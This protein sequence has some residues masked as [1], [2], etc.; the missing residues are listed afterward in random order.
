MFTRNPRVLFIRTGL[1]L[2]C[3][4]T[5]C[6]FH[7]REKCRLPPDK[8]LYCGLASMPLLN[9]P[10]LSQ[11]EKCYVLY[12]L[13]VVLHI[14]SDFL[15]IYLFNFPSG[16]SAFL[17]FHACRYQHRSSK[18]LLTAEQERELRAS[19]TPWLCSPCAQHPS[20]CSVGI[21]SLDRYASKIPPH[22]IR[23]H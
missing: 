16:T 8:C 5:I 23:L 15:S 10:L 19:P 12:D 21:P 14:S 20:G 2:K 7:E 11:N 13:L 17:W 6:F 22:I 3:L 9:H 1:K 18:G 4:H